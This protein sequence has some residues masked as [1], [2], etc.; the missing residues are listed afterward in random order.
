MT[1][2]KEL[3]LF[4]KDLKI[5]EDNFVDLFTKLHQKD[6]HCHP[7]SS[8]SLHLINDLNLNPRIYVN[9]DIQENTKSRL[10]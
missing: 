4:K 5:L 3:K 9:L 6:T 2:E 10:N 7:W 1:N 8:Y